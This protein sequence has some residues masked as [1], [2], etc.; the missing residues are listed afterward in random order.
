[1]RKM[2]KIS[3]VGNPNSGKTT[4]FNALTGAHQ[5][6]GNW[7]GVTVE[8]KSGQARIDDR[9][10]EFI[11]LPGLYDLNEPEGDTGL[12]TQITRKYLEQR[13]HDLLINVIDASCLARSLFLTTQ[14]LANGHSVIVVLNMVDVATS[15]NINIDCTAL[16]DALGCPVVPANAS[17]GQGISALK[18]V[19]SLYWASPAGT[20]GNDFTQ[21]TASDRYQQIDNIVQACCHQHLNDDSRPAWQLDQLLLNRWLAFPIFLGVMYSLFLFTINIGGAFIELFDGIAKALFVDSTALLLSAVNSPDW[22]IVLISNGVG[23]GIQ[24]VASFIPTIACLFLFLSFLEDSGYMARAAFIID[25]LM[26]S[27]G[28][29]GKAFVPLIVGFGC[30][31]PAVMASRTLDHQN[32]RLL[33]IMMAPFMSCGARLTVYVLFAAVFFP[34]NGQNIVFALYLSGIGLALLTGLILK[35]FMIKTHSTPFILELP[36]YHLPTARG[37]YLH[38]WQ[39]LK[40]FML[41]AGKA[42]VIVAFLM[43]LLS[44]MGTD[45]RFYSN[46]N[47]HSILSTIGKQITPILKPMGVDENNWPAT[48]GLFTG[49]FAKEVVVGTL[50]SLYTRLDQTQSHRQPPDPAHITNTLREAMGSVPKNLW[51]LSAQIADPLGIQVNEFTNKDIAAKEQGVTLTTLT[52]MSTLFNG[53]AGAFSYLLFVLLYSPC[54]ATLGAVIKETNRFWAGFIMSWATVSA[55]CIAV[56]FYQSA[57]FN[58][59]P[60]TSLQWIVAMLALLMSNHTLLIHLGR[61]VIHRPQLIPVINC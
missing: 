40:G 48:V 6:V 2:P 9:V 55:Y 49:L 18:E 33:S 39:R 42:I 51:N 45:G 46:Q 58:T 20:A 4:V 13:N 11:D 26:V 19:V 50:D 28:L 16:S 8:Q 34:E 1:M 57:N 23:G 36:N 29:P 54:V 38:T 25:R 35:K 37:I 59:N 7:P 27:M 10:F 15:Q 14:L 5:K 24:L 52:K 56:I 3:L 44:S 32:D 60:I 43:N 31:V 17:K 61:R 41:R 21:V 12:D 53:A 22:L 30:N 47:N